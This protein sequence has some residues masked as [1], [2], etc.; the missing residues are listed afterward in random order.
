M[1]CLRL[2]APLLLALA[3]GLAA[4]SA[5]AQNAEAPAK[6]QPPGEQTSPAAT[7]IPGPGPAAPEQLQPGDAFGAQVILP[8]RT[9]IY[10]QGE[11]KWDSAQDTLIDSFKSLD[12]YLDKRGIKPNGPPMTIYTETNDTG[13]RFR[14]AV[15]V[16]QVPKD[17]PKGDI[18]VGKTPSGKAL[19]FVH[20][21]S[22]DALDSTYE[23]ITDYLDDQGLDAKDVFIEEYASGP[24]QAGDDK[25]VVNV[26]V[27]VK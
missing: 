11:S 9:I 7:P 16:A 15:P 17:A 6:P 1:S 18:A 22:Y 26:F 4:G 3:L 5:A 13:F 10:M 14:A 20:R 24:L 27:P 12:E 23:A 21:G 8:E 19:K 25:L 2:A